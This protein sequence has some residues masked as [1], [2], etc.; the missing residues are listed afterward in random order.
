MRRAFALLVTAALVLCWWMPGVGAAE[1]LPD[2]EVTTGVLVSDDPA[3]YT[4]DQVLVVYTDGSCQVITYSDDEALAEG[5]A[6]LA[7]RSGVALVQPN[8]SYSSTALTTDDALGS[9]Q[10][11][12]SNDGSFY[13]EEAANRY[14]VYDDPFRTPSLPG[15]WT[16]PTGQPGMGQMGSRGT[17]AS[18]TTAAAG[19]DIDVETAWDLY[20]G[21]SR[22]VVI[23]LI[24]T[25][26]DTGHEDLSGILWVNEDE[27]PGNGID[28]DGNGYVD[29]INGWNFYH[30]SNVIDTGSEDSHGTH[31]AGTIAA[32]ADNGVGIAGIVQSDHVKIMVLKALGGAEGTGTTQSIIQAIQYAE[33]NGA[34]ICNLSLG[35]QWDDRALYQTMAASSMLFVVAAGNDGTNT[36]VRPSYPASYDLDNIIS[37]ANLNYDGT[38]HSSSNYGTVSVDLAAPGTYILSTTADG[39]YGYMTGTSMAAP[40]VTAAAAMVYSYFDGITLAGVKEILLSSA[41]TLDSLEGL[42]ATGGMLDLGAAMAYDL[43]SL[44]GAQWEAVQT[45]SA[46]GALAITT[47]LFSWGR[48]RYLLVRVSDTDGDLEVTAYASGTYT[49]ADFR[50]QGVGRAFSLGKDGT[51]LFTVRQRGSYTFYARDSAGHESVATVQIS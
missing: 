47:Q 37:V 24:D 40:M 38:L 42:T 10:W 30:N 15:Q 39:G 9:Q 5:L 41:Q 7:A 16:P 35:S 13:M 44:S 49:A 32:Q 43:D 23:A 51:A 21:G 22:D 6:Q 48:E 12:L 19:V 1:E 20:D 18:Q 33:A 25:G 28:D 3:D 14:P 45:D 26:V 27:I 46:T 36:D 29:D 4:G 11:A 31:G 8:Y 34:S 2:L 17:A 50:T